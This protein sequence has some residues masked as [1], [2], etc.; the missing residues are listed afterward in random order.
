MLCTKTPSLSRAILQS[1]SINSKPLA[2]L[3]LKINLS[4]TSARQFSE[5]NRSLSRPAIALRQAIS[6]KDSPIF[7]STLASIAASRRPFSVTTP[8]CKGL[9]PETENPQ[10]TEPEASGSSAAPAPLT[11][12]QYN[13]IS[14]DYMNAI[15]EKLEQLQ[16]ERE[17]V[18]VE[19]SV[20]APSQKRLFS[21]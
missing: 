9:S 7:N 5:V 19:Y 17:D 8:T 14:D 3:Y 12:Q 1:R 6:K 18:D 11:D 13:E 2:P 21:E 20:R 16:E 10:P 15:V 4:S